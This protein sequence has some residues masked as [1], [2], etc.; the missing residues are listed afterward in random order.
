MDSSHLP[1]HTCQG[2]EKADPVS[3]WARTA[4]DRSP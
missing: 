1:L 4:E 3:F 2:D